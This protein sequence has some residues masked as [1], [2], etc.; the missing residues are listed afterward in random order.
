MDSMGLFYGNSQ[1]A[2]LMGIRIRVG[3]DYFA[4][5]LTVFLFRQYDR[6][7]GKIV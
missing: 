3:W 2:G 5:F 6:V 1:E 7:V 4:F